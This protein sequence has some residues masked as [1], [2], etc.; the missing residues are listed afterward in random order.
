MSLSKQA[1]VTLIEKEVK[2]LTAYLDSDDYNNACDDA[3][4]ETGFSY[5]VADG[6]ATLW[7]KTR[8]KRHIFFYLLT[9]SAHKFKYEA[10]NLQHR[11]E[12]YRDIIKYMDEQWMI[13]Q[14][15]NALELAG[16]SGVNVLGTKFDAGFAYE[17]QTGRDL[18]YNEAN[19]TVISP[20]ETD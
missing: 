14:E 3:S 20:K 17:S 9:E 2:G 18:T 7:V 5:P 19:R 15:E 16:V 10:I 4:R 11:F 8:A 1:M 6:F 12:H 13:V